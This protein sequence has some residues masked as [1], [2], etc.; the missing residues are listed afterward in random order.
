MVNE[1][2][3]MNH[4]ECSPARAFATLAHG[5]DAWEDI[6]NFDEEKRV[7]PIIRRELLKV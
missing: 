2:F 4:N 7:V 3:Y 1:V 6:L 5:R